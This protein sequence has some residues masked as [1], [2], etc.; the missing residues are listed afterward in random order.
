MTL[1]QIIDEIQRLSPEDRLFLEQLLAEANDREWQD[2]LEKAR[3]IAKE[4]GIDQAAI[5]EAVHRVR[6]GT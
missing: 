1:Y 5:D 6:Y 4:R 2:E 3:S